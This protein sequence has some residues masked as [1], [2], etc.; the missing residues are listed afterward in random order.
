MM[1]I[2][3]NDLELTTAKWVERKRK[4]GWYTGS[5][6][7]K[8]LRDQNI[9]FTPEELI[10]NWILNTEHLDRDKDIVRRKY[11]VLANST[12]SITQLELHTTHSVFIGEIYM[13][14]KYIEMAYK[15]VGRK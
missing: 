10:F 5:K 14:K 9:Y 3:K 12:V 4:A 15:K 1:K 2:N 11:T 13:G 6:R 7:D 8:F